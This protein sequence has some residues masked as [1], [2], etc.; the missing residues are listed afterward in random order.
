MATQSETY[1]AEGNV[2]QI[3][4]QEFFRGKNTKKV[5]VD[6]GAARPDYLSVSALYR[7]AGWRIIAI[8]PNPEFCELHKAKGYEVLQ[9]ACGDHDE[10]DVD[11]C[12]VNSHGA[13][14]A[15]GNVS[16]ESFSSLSIKDSYAS[17]QENLDTKTIKVNLR[18]LDSILK[19]Y[20]PD[21]SRIDILSVDVEG[22]ELEVINGLN[23]SKYRPRVMVIENLFDDEKYR[24]YME[25]IDYTLWKCLP[26][27]DVYVSSELLASPIKRLYFYLYKIFVRKK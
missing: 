13:E 24:T 18:R 2:D 26:P 22:W 23:I 4:Q 5:F 10:D 19:N 20:A 25:N 11:F 8:E 6:V 12:I 15:D 1:K 9:F 27:N 14:Y 17:L 7:A 3:I 16:Y 21:I